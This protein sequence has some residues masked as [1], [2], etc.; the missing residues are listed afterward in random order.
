MIDNQNG[1]PSR[2]VVVRSADFA[3]RVVA[4]TRALR[5]DTVSREIAKQLVSAG[6]SVGANVEESQAAESTNDFLHKL[7]I[8][9]KECREARFFLVRIANA[10]LLPERRL[11]PLIDEA[12][13]LINMMTAIIKSTEQSG[14]RSRCRTARPGLSTGVPDRRSTRNS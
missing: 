9:R 1:H 8:A 10:K 5:A 11:R 6:M 14:G 3:D 12:T 4:C 7:R 2:G 13:Q